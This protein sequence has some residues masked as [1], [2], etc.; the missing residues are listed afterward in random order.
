M[1]KDASGQVIRSESLGTS[2]YKPLT[3]IVEAGP[4]IEAPP[5]TEEAVSGNVEANIQESVSSEQPE[6]E[7]IKE[8]EASKEPEPEKVEFADNTLE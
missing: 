4:A 1:V 5:V 2:V 3:K 6:T 8:S 7:E